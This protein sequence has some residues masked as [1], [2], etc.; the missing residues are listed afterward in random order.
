M[1]QHTKA[2]DNKA[3]LP[4]WG[5]FLFQH[6]CPNVWHGLKMSSVPS[7]RLCRQ[8]TAHHF[9]MEPILQVDR[10]MVI[11]MEKEEEKGGG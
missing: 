5:H 11:Y 4:I 10:N 2:L 9:G 7:S 8:L 1:L 3:M 6:E